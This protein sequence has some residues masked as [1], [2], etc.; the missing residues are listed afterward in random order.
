M[1]ILKFDTRN[2]NAVLNEIG[3]YLETILR[4]EK[5]EIIKRCLQEFETE[6]RKILVFT[7]FKLHSTLDHDD[8]THRIH[9]EIVDHREENNSND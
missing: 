8:Q 3:I 2:M 4:K 5:E 1:S 9:I 6:L 7:S